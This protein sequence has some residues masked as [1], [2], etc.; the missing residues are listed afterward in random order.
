MKKFHTK[1]NAWGVGGFE[2]LTTG[3]LSVSPASHLEEETPVSMTVPDF[4]GQIHT[5]ANQRRKGGR[6]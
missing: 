3:S 2:E 5:V 1:S 4:K 6:G